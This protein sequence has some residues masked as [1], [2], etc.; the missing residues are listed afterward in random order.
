MSR[1]SYIC[2]NCGETGLFAKMPNFCP[3]CG[4]TDIRKNDFEAREHAKEIAEEM[5]LLVPE[6]E[7]TWSAYVNAYVEF[8][9]RRRLLDGYVRRGIIDKSDIPTVEKKKLSDALYEY[10]AMRKENGI[11]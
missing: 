5:K 11:S 8:E 3:N 9:N 10:R 2:M 7:N 1:K 6:I 4:S